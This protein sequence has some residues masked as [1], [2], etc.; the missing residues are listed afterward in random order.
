MAPPPDKRLLLKALRFFGFASVLFNSPVYI[1][2]H[3]DYSILNL[4][5]S[6]LIRGH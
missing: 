5:L 1:L 2:Y 3:D 6:T 4:G